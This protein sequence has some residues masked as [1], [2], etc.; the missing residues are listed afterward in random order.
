[1]NLY[2]FTISSR[3]LFGLD[4]YLADS[5]YLLQHH[6]H[7]FVQYSYKRYPH[8]YS[9]LGFAHPLTFIGLLTHSLS[10]L[11]LPTHFHWFTHPL[12]FIGL[13]T[14]S[15]SLLY[16]PTHFHW[17]THLLTFI[18]LLTRSLSLVYSPTHISQLHVT[19]CNYLHICNYCKKKG[20]KQT[21]IV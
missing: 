7:C 16:S 17:S 12:T 9:F 21:Y 19:Y 8:P 3:K 4:S 6:L 14:H 20:C 2:F 18:G 10:L 15:L 13:L 1:M 5:F 11:Y